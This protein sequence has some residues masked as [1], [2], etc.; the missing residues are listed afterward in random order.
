M[1]RNS[2]QMRM[3]NHSYRSNNGHNTSH[4]YNKSIVHK[5]DLEKPAYEAVEEEK[6]VVVQSDGFTESEEEYDEQD[7]WYE[8]EEKG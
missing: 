6:D 5:T 2:M 8:E 3:T 1:A 4:Q 7:D